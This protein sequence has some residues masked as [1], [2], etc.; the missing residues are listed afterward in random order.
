MA[1]V[2]AALVVRFQVLLA[3]AAAVLAFWVK[4]QMV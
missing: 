3:A 2:A 1:L 4:V